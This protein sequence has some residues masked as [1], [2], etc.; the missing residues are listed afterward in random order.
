MNELFAPP[1][2]KGMTLRPYQQEAVDRVL[3]GWKEFDKQLLVLPTGGGKTIVFSKIVEALQPKRSLILC[4]QNELIEQAVDKLHQATGIMADVDKAERHASLRADC[5]V[6]TVQSMVRRLDKYSP[7]HFAAIICDEAHLSVSEI[8][9]KV[10]AYFT[11][12]KILGVTATP[13]R[14]DSKQL[15]AFYQNLA[16]EVKLFDLIRQGFLSRISV[17]TLDLEIDISSVAQNQGDYD[18]DQLDDVL[19]PYF[20]KICEA[21]KTY[22]A[23]RKILVFLPL[24]KTSKNF[25]DACHRHG[26]GAKHIDGTSEDRRLILQEF[27]DDHFR[28]LGNSM[29]LT[30]GFDEPS[31]DCVINLR[32]TRSRTLYSQM[33]GRGT[34]LFNGKK[35]LLI[36]DFLW[37]FEKHVIMN[38]AYLIAKNEDQARRMTKKFEKMKDYADLEFVDSEVAREREED[39]ANALKAKRGRGQYFDAAEY[40]ARIQDQEMMDYEPMTSNESQPPTKAQ[41]ER[42]EKAGFVMETIKGR[43][44]ADMIISKLDDRRQRGLA[45]L[46]QVYW[47]E[48]FNIPNADNVTFNEASH[49]LDEKFS[50]GRK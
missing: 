28:V 33:I 18:K 8:W 42:L 50:K 19:T 45:T 34:R 27:R 14:S 3:T 41:T 35:D 7:D 1:T 9:Q 31:I 49:I 17:R 30:T 4:H 44:H 48:R 21:I 38:P 25:V 47:L 15:M 24:I 39:L 2:S 10:L 11:G 16:Y 36:L 46:K 37:M 12:A 40:A 22:A 5:V 43:A 32:P 6:A 20:D 23:E 13:D 29:L 26:I